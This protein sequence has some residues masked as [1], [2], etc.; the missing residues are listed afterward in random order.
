MF[1]L[2]GV[3]VQYT[4]RASTRKNG[5]L[6]SGQD[7]TSTLGDLGMDGLPTS[8]T[9]NV[10]PT[11]LYQLEFATQLSLTASNMIWTAVPPPVIATNQ[12]FKF[13]LPP[14]VGQPGDPMFFQILH[15]PQP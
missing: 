15:L 11:E 8:L 3:D 5:L 9:V 1:T 2:G 6:L 10:V 7:L 12:V 4:I 13:P 14:P